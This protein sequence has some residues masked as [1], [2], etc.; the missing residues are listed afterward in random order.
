MCRVENTYLILQRD[1]GRKRLTFTFY[2]LKKQEEKR[3]SQIGIPE[4]VKATRNST[5]ADV[6]AVN[7][8]LES[9]SKKKGR[10]GSSYDTSI[11]SRV[12]EEVGKYAYNNGTQT[13]INCFKSKYSQYT[14]LRT[15]IDN[16]KCKFNNQ[17]ENLLLPIFSKRGRSNAM[18]D[19]LLQGILEEVIGI[20]LLEL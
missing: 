15:C 4:L 7:A 6:S 8:E 18:R 17:K 9:F 19:D 2:K 20:R 16:W 10:K 11:H 5:A 1:H 12:K 3:K 13:A 14:F